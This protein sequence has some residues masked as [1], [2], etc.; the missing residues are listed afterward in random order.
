M[1]QDDARQLVDLLKLAV[2][3]RCSCSNG[4]L[5]EALA[6]VLLALGTANV[7]TKDMILELCVTEVRLVIIR[8]F[9]NL[10]K[11]EMEGNF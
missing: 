1:Y 2:A 7:A 8:V 6:D 11:F 4:S 3:G 10:D 9:T 5:K